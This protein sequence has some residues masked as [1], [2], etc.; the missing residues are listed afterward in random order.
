MLQKLQNNKLGLNNLDQAYLKIL[1]CR[2]LQN[3]FSKFLVSRPT[4]WFSFSDEK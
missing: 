3:K 4:L 1:C 2:N